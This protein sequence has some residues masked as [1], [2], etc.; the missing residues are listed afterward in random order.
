MFFVDAAFIGSHFCL[1]AARG[2]GSALEEDATRQAACG[3]TIAGA[4]IG[5]IDA[6]GVRRC[7]V[8]IGVD[9]GIPRIVDVVDEFGADV[10]I[11]EI[12]GTRQDEGRGIFIHIE[13]VDDFGDE[14]QDAA[15]FLEMRERRDPFLIEGVEDFG[16]DG[17]TSQKPLVVGVGTVGGIGRIN[18]FLGILIH[19]GECAAYSL[20]FV[21][22]DV[23]G[24]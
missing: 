10:A 20:A 12:D 16:M 11:G 13:F 9:D 1:N 18:A 21:E 7:A 4:W 5:G 19:I 22:I 17:V 24:E 3:G 23:I 8:D 15:R 14:A 2:G 6:I